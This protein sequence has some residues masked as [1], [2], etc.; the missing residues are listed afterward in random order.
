M[1]ANRQERRSGE[2]PTEKDRPQ[3]AAEKVVE[4]C[5]IIGKV[6][7]I[8]MLSNNGNGGGNQPLGPVKDLTPLEQ[9]ALAEKFGLIMRGV[10]QYLAVNP[11]APEDFEVF[12]ADT[13]RAI[14]S[15][16]PLAPLRN[17]PQWVLWRWEIPKGKDKPT[18]VPYR[19]IAPSQK[20]S[21][22]AQ[23]CW[24]NY[25]DAIKNVHR[26]S[27]IGFALAKGRIAAFD[28]DKCRNPETGAISPWARKLID[29][30]KTYVEIT[31][32]GT[33]LRI[34]GY[35]NGDPVHQKFPV[36]DCSLEIYRKAPRYITVTGDALEGYNVDFMNIDAV[37]D[38]VKRDD[39]APEPDP[40]QDD[41]RTEPR[42]FSDVPSWVMEDVTSRDIGERGRKLYGIIIDL[43]ELGWSASDIE[44]VLLKYPDS[45][46]VQKYKG[47][48][49]HEIRRAYGKIKIKSQPDNNGGP[50][51]TRLKTAA[52]FIDEH[53]PLNYLLEPIIDAGALYTLTA[54]TGN[55][56]TAFLLLL[57]LAISCKRR[58]LFRNEI[59]CGRTA[60]L[61][62]ENP[63]NFRMRL[64]VSIGELG[65][66]KKELDDLLIQ[67]WFGT[68]AEMLALLQKHEAEGGPFKLIII[69]TLASFFTGDNSN[70]NSQL[71]AFLR[72]VRPL[73]ALKENPTVIIATHPTKNATDDNLVPYGGG[74]ILN[75][76]DGNL[77]MQ[78]LTAERVILHWQGK[79]R[80][81]EFDPLTFELQV[82]TSI[83]VADK[84]GALIPMPFLECCDP[85]KVASTIN[86]EGG[87]KIATL[88]RIADY[89][90]ISQADLARALGV[91]QGIM[92]K[93]LKAFAT[94]QWVSQ[95]PRG[96]YK[97]TKK[98]QAE[99]KDD[100]GNVQDGD[101]PF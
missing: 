56:K 20:A 66:A 101:M 48:L 97:I 28:L 74:A 24:G 32:S 6:K 46:I 69:D 15:S 71:M 33:G 78:K 12:C 17:L 82:K 73:T 37:I 77:T 75:E 19:V 36:E 11:D 90:G 64:M 34:I 55:C 9:A 41:A 29:M 50:R 4:I 42:D 60:Y 83:T 76:V 23:G 70:D 26:A 79:I 87:L 88:Q 5:A 7:S 65:I 58:D 53:Q 98:G 72:A 18:K 93:W 92:S 43:K 59:E 21:S 14:S 22:T 3:R 2:P 68:P 30:C 54:K 52:E 86:E 47:R 51:P 84:K 62:C 49:G 61:T 10:Q 99:L 8:D 44:R 95:N 57:A 91:R 100:P 35:G 85:A 25:K 13:E 89:P 96:G 16:G 38:R 80:G 63:R 40:I 39:N 45:G 31:P 81:I 94:K 27:G 67:D 1:C